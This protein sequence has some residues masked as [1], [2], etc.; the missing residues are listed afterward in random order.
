MQ[1]HTPPRKF[2]GEVVVVLLVQ[3]HVVD[4]MPFQPVG[5][6]LLVVLDPP[7]VG[8]M[9]LK[10]RAVD[11]VL[12]AI[13]EPRGLETTT[14]LRSGEVQTFFVGPVYIIDVADV[15][16]DDI[17]LSRRHDCPLDAKGSVEVPFPRNVIECPD[18]S[19]ENL[20]CSFLS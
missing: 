20:H 4:A 18:S 1:R 5:I 13:E 3:V 9:V 14:V 2:I 16:G 17:V 11:T 6:H 10:L 8:E 19:V 15:L 12:T 7:Q